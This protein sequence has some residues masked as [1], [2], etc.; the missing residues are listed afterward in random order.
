MDILQLIFLSYIMRAVYIW[1][2]HSVT[3][4]GKILYVFMQ[5]QIFFTNHHGMIVKGNMLV[6]SFCAPR[7]N[8]LH[9]SW[10]T[11]KVILRKQ[12]MNLSMDS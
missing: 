11:G 6:I 7:V 3:M 12:F 5:K 9:I 4:F 10:I 1:V 8:G 2:S